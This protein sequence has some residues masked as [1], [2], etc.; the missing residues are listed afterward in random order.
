MRSINWNFVFIF[1]VFCVL[2]IFSFFA[3]ND[4][5]IQYLGLTSGDELPQFKQLNSVLEGYLNFDLEKMFRI[6]F[7]NYGYIYYILNVIVTAP[8]NL[9][10]KYDWAIFAPRFLNGIFS[11]LNLWV[12]YKICNIYLK[13]KESIFIVCFYL[14]IPGFWYFGFIFKPAILQT[15]FVLCSVYFLCL[16]SFSYKKNF[17]LSVLMLGLGVGIAKFQALMFV[18][19]LCFYVCIPF[20]QKTNIKNFYFG[21]FYSIGIVLAIFVLWIVTNPYIL[22]PIGMK[23]WWNMFEF[24]MTSNATNHGTYTVVTFYD[25]I[26]ML[27]YYF[28]SPLILLTIVVFCVKEFV[29]KRVDKIWYCIF[30]TCF[31]T[32]LYLLLF[33]NKDW[34][35]YYIST[36]Y[37]GV[38]LLIPIF[39]RY[40]KI[41][42]VVFCMQLL[43][44]FVFDSYELFNKTP[45]DKT[46]AISLSNEI[47]EVLK[48]QEI[49][50]RVN[51][52]TDNPNFSYHELGLTYRNIHQMFGSVM[53]YLLNRERF[54]KKY[55]YKN[56]KKYFTQYDFLIIS[57]E[58]IM[59]SKAISKKD[60]IA[61]TSIET[62]RNLKKYDYC[63]IAESKHFLFYS[64]CG[65]HK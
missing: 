29:P 24:N 12:I 50:S 49:N 61:R 6:E 3:W 11:V 19:M 10:G 63:Q 30:F 59:R 1:I 54:Q 16:D 43:N 25:K 38:L 32:L 4:V 9:M 21:F 14:L 20:F 39:Q 44:I 35:K 18:P 58:L 23:V 36:I 26:Y 41:L 13:K 17:Y 33:V 52:Y 56:P 37:L 31:V 57:K 53:P 46:T 28:L 2:G 48:K 8:F 55:P 51:I 62:I 47:L 65:G 60:E 7:Y 27:G 45:K 40:K 42:I 22:H 64:Y 34:G 5:D 15:F